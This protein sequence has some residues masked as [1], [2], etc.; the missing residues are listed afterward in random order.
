MLF[1]SQGLEARWADRDV[2]AQSGSNKRDVNVGL[3][4]WDWVLGYVLRYCK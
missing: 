1:L 3:N 2:Q 4:D